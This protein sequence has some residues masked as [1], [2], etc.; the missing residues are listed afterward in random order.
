M[1]GASGNRDPMIRAGLW[2]RNI[3]RTVSCVAHETKTRSRVSAMHCDH[4]AMVIAGFVCKS[5]K[6]FFEKENY[7]IVW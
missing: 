2:S 6:T 7:A 3:A 5:V 4:L 1:L